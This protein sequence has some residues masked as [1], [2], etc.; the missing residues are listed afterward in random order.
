MVIIIPPWT[1][2]SVGCFLLT[3]GDTDVEIGCNEWPFKDFFY[4]CFYPKW[5]SCVNGKGYIKRQWNEAT[6]LCTFTLLIF[7][8]CCMIITVL[9][10]FEFF[11][12]DVLTVWP[13]FCFNVT[14]I[15]YVLVVHKY[16][17]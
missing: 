7:S 13:Q 5:F 17:M 8:P 6:V 4:I 1:L 15:C 3:Y 11:M 9:L 12:F 16:I 2:L 10:M 14:N